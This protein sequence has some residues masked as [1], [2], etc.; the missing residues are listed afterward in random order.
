VATNSADYANLIANYNLAQ[1][2]W[3]PGLI[4][5]F[6]PNVAGD[7]EFTLS[8]YSGQNL[9]ASTGMTVTVVPLPAALW[10]GLA[11]IGTLGVAKRLRRR[12]QD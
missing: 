10:V 11:M 4:S 9:L 5:G 7:Y 6:N 8:A 1:N 2:S 12:P 3:N